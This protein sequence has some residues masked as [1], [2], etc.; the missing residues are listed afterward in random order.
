MILAR[1][2]ILE[3]TT[4][5]KLN[6]PAGGTCTTTDCVTT[7][8]YT[9]NCP[10]AYDGTNCENV[11][12]FTYSTQL[13][14]DMEYC[15]A[16]DTSMTPRTQTSADAFCQAGGGVLAVIHSAADAYAVRD[17]LNS[18][19]LSL[20]Q[21]ADRHVWIGL[22]DTVNGVYAWSNSDAST[23]RSWAACKLSFFSNNTKC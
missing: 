1:I 17:Y 18:Q 8:T 19:A 12:A 3:S 21:D 13:I 5:A 11:A 22:Q 16:L 2:Y 4:Q 6:T 20:F 14:P 23:Y 15:Y 9:C 10:S 7:A